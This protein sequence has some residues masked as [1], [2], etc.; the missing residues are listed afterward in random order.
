MLGLMPPEA[1][2]IRGSCT[3]PLVFPSFHLAL[4]LWREND[5]ES[6]PFNPSNRP[7]FRAAPGKLEAER[8]APKAQKRQ[9]TC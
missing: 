6:R 4:A 5:P 7:L 8:F 1:L 2:S 9:A 3:K